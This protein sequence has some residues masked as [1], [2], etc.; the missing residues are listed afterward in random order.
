MAVHSTLGG[1]AHGH[2]G[3]VLTPAQYALLRQLWN[4]RNDTLH[5]EGITI[6]VEEITAIDAEILSQW[7][8]GYRQL[9]AC[10]KHLFTGEFKLLY[11]SD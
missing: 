4:D 2:L 5:G 6:Y 9:P 11:Q 8:K 3:L 1:G 7:T 10:Y